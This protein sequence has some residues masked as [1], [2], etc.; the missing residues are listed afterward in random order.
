MKTIF[1][2]GCILLCG[3]CFWSCATQKNEWT[4]DA[5]EILN[6]R[7]ASNDAL[8]VYD[9]EKELSFMT[10]DVFITTGNGTLIQGTE[11]LREYIRTVPAEKMYWVRTPDEIE[12]NAETGLAWE[13][14][15]WKGYQ[16]DAG[17]EPVT[18]GNY[19]AMWTR[20]D[21]SWKIKSELFVT[22]P[23]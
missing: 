7:Q 16:P 13:S 1:A 14:G 5:L 21:G 3:L 20:Q 8:K 6:V 12:V 11:N 18:G 4:G 17:Q 15:T 22:L 9:V 10:D 19:A 23:D 2:S